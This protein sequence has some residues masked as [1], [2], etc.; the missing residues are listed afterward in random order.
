MQHKLSHAIL[1]FFLNVPDPEATLNGN[2][3]TETQGFELSPYARAQADLKFT[4]VVTC[5]IYG[6]QKAEGKPEAAD[7]ALLMQRYFYFITNCQSIIVILQSWLHFLMHNF[8]WM[9]SE[10]KLSGLPSL[11]RLR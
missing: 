4:Y 5:Q 6:K 1:I 11:T 3:C 10:M 7:I 9:V 8:T 2:A